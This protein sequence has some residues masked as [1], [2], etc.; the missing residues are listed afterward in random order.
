MGQIKKD[1]KNLSKEAGSKT[2]ARRS[3]EDWFTKASKSIRDNTVSKL[4]APFKI[5]M[6]HVFRYEKPK[7]IKRYHGGI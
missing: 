2:K 7:N 3:A 5:G 4:S 1:I 6:I